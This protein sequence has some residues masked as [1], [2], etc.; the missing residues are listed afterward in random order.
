M[1]LKRRDKNAGPRERRTGTLQMDNRHKLDFEKAMFEKR[2]VRLSFYLI[3]LDWLH[4]EMV[5]WETLGYV[6]YIMNI[7]KTRITWGIGMG[8]ALHLRKEIS[9]QPK[10]SGTL[11]SCP[12][13]HS[14]RGSHAR[15]LVFIISMH[16]I[17]CLLHEYVSNRTQHCSTC[18][19]LIS[20]GRL[21][22]FWTFF[23]TQHCFYDLSCW[24]WLQVSCFHS[25][26]LCIS[27]SLRITLSF[28]WWKVRFPITITTTA[29]M[30]FLI[31]IS[32]RPTCA[33]ES[34]T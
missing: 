17:V 27:K 12:P 20:V 19:Q 13:A 9:T 24:R 2:N 14:P 1:H 16:A 25:S 23:P 21:H 3:W 8:P 32:L 31:H 30:D 34:T 6:K 33:S 10:L 28:C 18:L 26:I 29:A 22:V 11:W 5:I 4:V 15:G 7:F